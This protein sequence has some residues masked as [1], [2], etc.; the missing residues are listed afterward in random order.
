MTVVRSAAVIP[1]E[2]GIQ[3]VVSRRAVLVG[4]GAALIAPRGLIRTAW[5]AETIPLEIVPYGLA[6]VAARVGDRA[7]RALVDTGAVQAVQ[8]SSRLA[9]SL[10]LPV[11]ANRTVDLPRLTVGGRS[12]AEKAQ[13]VDGDIE[14]VAT[15][16][17]TEFD[18]VLGWPYLSRTPFALDYAASALIFDD[19]N[20][21]AS[22]W[23]ISLVGAAP[24]PVV[25]AF[26]DGRPLRALV[27]TG[28]PVSNLDPRRVDAPAGVML[29]RGLDLAGRSTRIRF[30]VQ[31][32]AAV[33]TGLGCD[34]VLGHAFLTRYR[35]RF[36][37]TGGR[38]ALQ[39]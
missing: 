2:A 26:L 19:A 9:A 32:L 29:E 34:A 23:H 33:R 14:R 25:D 37:R 11:A 36:D 28:A 20:D 22:S 13:V 27:D 5:A 6:F 7:V 38:L 15:E 16:I 3:F 18:V 35:V 30:R 24:V 10:K 39:S 12:G 8:V 17:G 1:A 31:D 21:P 4:A